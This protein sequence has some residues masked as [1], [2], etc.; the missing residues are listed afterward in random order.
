MITTITTLLQPKTVSL[1]GVR[2]KVCLQSKLYGLRVGVGLLTERDGDKPPKVGGNW[3]WAD[4]ACPLCSE[5]V[6][7][8]TVGDSFPSL[9]QY[10]TKTNLGKNMKTRTRA[11]ANNSIAH[12]RN[13]PHAASYADATF[14]VALWE[15]AKRE[16]FVPDI[17][18]LEGFRSE[19]ILAATIL[20]QHQTSISTAI[21][22]SDEKLK[23]TDVYSVLR[24]VL[25]RE[26]SYVR[27]KYIATLRSIYRFIIKER[28]S[29]TQPS[30]PYKK[31]VKARALAMSEAIQE[32]VTKVKNQ[33]PASGSVEEFT[34]D[35]VQQALE[36]E[37]AKAL[38]MQLMRVSN[39]PRFPVSY[40]ATVCLRWRCIAGFMARHQR[41]S[42]D[43]NTTSTQS[44][45]APP[46]DA[47][48]PAPAA[49]AP[50]AA[51]TTTPA[52]A[53]APAAAAAAA[54]TTPPEAPQ[55]QGAKP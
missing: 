26:E 49:A 24:D 35:D 30:L 48:A 51:T 22:P 37:V 44:A 9:T 31:K 53:S 41:N 13:I 25:T 45:A 55:Q 42:K 23:E 20:A 38:S 16:D 8:P 6:R 29:A 36:T 7:L 14:P 12:R 2:I 10:S 50:A 3:E 32:A 34:N 28:P 33:F 40:A 1:E 15:S 52:D 19:D 5:L 27:T 18:L 11:H 46:A 4:L 43:A 47:S 21:V 39:V 54:T 17:E